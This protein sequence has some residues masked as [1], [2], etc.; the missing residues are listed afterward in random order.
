MRLL[1]ITAFTLIATTSSPTFAAG[2]VESGDGLESSYSVKVNQ[3]TVPVTDWGDAFCYL[4]VPSGRKSDVEIKMPGPIT[5]WSLSPGRGKIPVA[6][7]N[8]VA[9]F[10]IPG[11]RYLSFQAGGGKTLLLFAE[12]LEVNPP[13]PGDANVSD[14]REFGVHPDSELVQTGLLNQAISKIATMPGKSVLYFSKGVYRSGTLHLQS[15]VTLYLAEGAI[16]KASDD[17]AHF[18]RDNPGGPYDRLLFISAYQVKDCGI[19][20]RGVIDGNGLRLQPL[21]AGLPPRSVKGRPGNVDSNRI[22]NVQFSHVENGFVEGVISRNSSSWNTL[23]HYCTDFHVRNYKVL[24]NMVNKNDD[25]IDI[26]SCVRLDVR[27]SFFMA[28]DDGI[29]LKTC[30]T[31]QGQAIS[32][33]GSAR[34]MEDVLISNNTVWS[35]TAALKYGFNE[36]EASTIRRV[37][38]E[39]NAVLRAREGVQIRTGG[40]AVFQDSVFVGNWYGIL[41]AS[42]HDRNPSYNY[43][44]D[45]PEARH[46]QFLDE[47]HEHIAAGGS[48]IKASDLLFENLSMGG[49]IITGPGEARFHILGTDVRFKIR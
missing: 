38:F 21:L 9:R 27:D 31:F 8:N 32:P 48:D 28:R 11:P 47:V 3:Q 19:R 36:S 7:A 4:S 1:P 5:T 22:V 15:G 13:H 24:S 43:R 23:L 25:G 12:P 6:V 33:D 40:P 2:T 41:E 44:L 17:P 34:D 26:D 10:A 14:V 18:T 37:R 20:G 29:V 46:L 35:E 30:G 42:P 45:D 39:K 49:K 16:L